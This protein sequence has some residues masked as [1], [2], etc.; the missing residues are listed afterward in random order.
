MSELV[1]LRGSEGKRDEKWKKVER[2]ETRKRERKETKGVKQEM[3][4]RE[5][6]VRSAGR[7]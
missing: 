2:F 7:E 3:R 1:C 4:E 6:S 5:S